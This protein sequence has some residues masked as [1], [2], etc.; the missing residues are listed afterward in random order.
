MTKRDTDPK[1]LPE[2]KA[3]ARY[4]VCTRT[5]LR[6][7]DNPELGFPPCFMILGRRYREVDALDAWDR[8]NSLK[9]AKSKRAA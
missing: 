8:A 2:V 4:G 1:Y 5:L 3:A 6:W 7:D 9:A